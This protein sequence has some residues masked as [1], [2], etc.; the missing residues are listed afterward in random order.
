MTAPVTPPVDEPDVEVAQAVG[1]PAGLV[2][3]LVTDVPRMGEWS[4]ET[5][6]CRWLDGA[7]GPAV[8][9]RFTGSNHRGPLR[10]STACTV[11]AAY[12]GRL[13]AF[14]V[15]WARVPIAEWA[16]R[17][18]PDGAGCTVVESWSDRRPAMMR[19]ASV[20]VMGIADRAEHNRRGMLAT[21]AALKAAAEASASPRRR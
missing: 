18:V 7:T 15:S 17:F 9:A 2:Y 11:T 13:F 20:P 1:A 16:Y 12:T 3:D 14:R 8:G 4:R 10:W 6:S 21:L 5:S 19:L